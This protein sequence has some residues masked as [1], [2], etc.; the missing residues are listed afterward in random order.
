MNS[1]MSIRLRKFEAK[2]ATDLVSAQIAPLRLPGYGGVKMTLSESLG[3]ELRCI[4]S[5]KPS[6]ADSPLVARGLPQIFANSERRIYLGKDYSHISYRPV[7]QSKNI[8]PSAMT[9]T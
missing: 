5:N 7:V 1:F 4:T 3:Y 6:P 2:S 8:L 9:E